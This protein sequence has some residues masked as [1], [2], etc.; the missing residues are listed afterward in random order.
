MNVHIIM[1]HIIDI[2][3][4]TITIAFN[5]YSMPFLILQCS[6]VVYDSLSEFR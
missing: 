1:E 3:T 5:V 2:I 4:I 6:Q